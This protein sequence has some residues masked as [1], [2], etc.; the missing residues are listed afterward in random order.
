MNKN[1]LDIYRL[2]Q[3][4]ALNFGS[5]GIN[6]ECCNDLSFVEFMALKSIY[7]NDDFSVQGVGNA[8]NFTKS[9]ATR[10]INRLESKGYAIRKNSLTDG[11]ICCVASTEKGNK[12]LE[13]TTENYVKYLE[14]ILQEFEP[15]KVEGIK[16][17]LEILVN[18]VQK[19][20]PFCALH[21]PNEGVKSV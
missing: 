17:S 6:G 11:R 8:L 1:L 20:K 10:I 14:E 15:E 9:G 12:M 16:N 3:Q 21:K 5:H 13:E 19:N 7:E 4:I 18:V 2:V